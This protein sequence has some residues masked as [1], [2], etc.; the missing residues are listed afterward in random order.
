VRIVAFWDIHGKASFP[1]L[2]L[3]KGNTVI[4]AQ[5]NEFD[6]TAGLRIEKKSDSHSFPI[7]R[8]YFTRKL[9][10]LASHL[11]EHGYC[12]S[13]LPEMSSAL[14]RQSP[15]LSDAH[16][17]HAKVARGIEVFIARR[18]VQLGALEHLLELS[19]S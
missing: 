11:E 16:L 14:G 4:V 18:D 17:C 12:I 9:S 13:D 8:F 10:Q 15:F 1:V 2:D 6:E 7:R 5:I 19:R 3:F